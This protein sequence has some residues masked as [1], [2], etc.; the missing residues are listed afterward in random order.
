MP[1]KLLLIAVTITAVVSQLL[2]RR[3]VSQLGSPLGLAGLLRFIAQAVSSP[4]IY[5]AVSVQVIG[6]ILWMMVLARTKLGVAAASIGAGFYVLLALAAWLFY[7]ET[8]STFQWIGIAFVTMG[9]ICIS[10]GQT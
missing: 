7:D 8:L 4:W 2:L 6:Y 5:A 1:L 3:A 9:V 10:L